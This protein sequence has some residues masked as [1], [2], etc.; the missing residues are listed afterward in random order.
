MALEIG[1]RIGIYEVTAKLGEG[2]MGTVYRAH[3]TTLDRD[4]ALKVLSEGFTADPD[5]LARFQREAKV[6]ASLNHPNIGGIYG[7]ESAGDA[8]ALVLE[9]IEG[10][11]L[12]DRIA[13]GPMLVDDAVAI[14]KQIAEALEA[15]HEQGIIHRDLKP[16]NVKVRLDG[17]VKV[18]DFGLAKAISVGEDATA[19]ADQATMSLTGA[20][21]MGMVI[22]TAAYMAP[23]QAKGK[24]VD[25]RAD[26]WAFGVVL[27]EMLVGRRVFEGETASETI[28]AVMMKEPEW[29]RLPA[30]LPGTLDTVVRRCLKKDPRERM[31]DVGDVRLAL[32]GAFESTVA[33]AGNAT[34]DPERPV[35]QRPVVWL[36]SSLLLLSALLLF[37]VSVFDS[38]PVESVRTQFVERPAERMTFPRSARAVAISPDG[39]QLVYSAGNL[40]FLRRFDELETEKIPGTEGAGAPFFSP[41]GQWVGFFTETEIR[42]VALSGGAPFTVAE[43]TNGLDGAWSEDDTI[44][45][46][47]VG[48]TPLFQVSA[49]GG[50][51]EALTERKNS[52]VDHDFPDFLPGGDVMLFSVAPGGVNFDAGQIV[53]QRLS[54]GERRV[55]IEGGFYPRWL[56]SGHLLYARAGGLFVAPFD[57]DVLEITGDPREIVSGV[58]QSGSGGQYST[59]REGAL[60]YLPGGVTGGQSEKILVAVDRE[61]METVLPT[62]SNEFIGV[63]VSPDG[64]RV[65]LEVASVENFDVWISDVTRGT[66]SRLTTNPGFDEH[67]LWTSDGSGLVFASDRSGNWGI[68]QQ[69][70]DGREGAELLVEIADALPFLVPNSWTPD[71]EQLVFSYRMPGRS[72]DIGVLENDGSGDWSPLLDSPNLEKSASVSPDGEWVAYVSNETGASEVFLE[73]FPGLGLK[74]QISVDGGQHPIWSPDGQELYYRT[75]DTGALMSVQLTVDPTLTIGPPMQLGDSNYALS[76]VGLRMYDLFPD[77]NRFLMFRE[78]E[79]ETHF[80]QVVLN[81]FNEL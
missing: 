34:S 47:I 68:Y 38:A 20:T 14:A 60:V 70:V 31:R 49:Q 65:A 44:V 58:M 25:K 80:I 50:I 79:E 53:A 8:Q 48:P 69:N 27:L 39:R 32:S 43:V 29:E 71:D 28:A 4:V 56:S 5:R 73:P 21:Q 64:R 26:I 55:V 81:A 15:A 63:S 62:A 33:I 67:P 57:A 3:D 7:L 74:T 6:L 12:A 22:G 42:K 51:P 59:S 41:D 76:R 75:L 9:L 61:G 11:T 19:S 30:H 37:T 36:C 23:E 10:Q 78:V 54:T 46:G 45:F 17:R 2:G 66:L 13:D 72:F 77:G 18:L 16:A 40:L 52:N 35:W 1:T 24:P